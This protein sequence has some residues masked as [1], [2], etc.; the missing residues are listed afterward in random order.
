MPVI[1]HVLY[2]KICQFFIYNDQNLQ[3]KK[4]YARIITDVRLCLHV[5]LV[6]TRAPVSSSDI[7]QA[8]PPTSSQE[9]GRA[10]KALGVRGSTE[11]RCVPALVAERENTKT[12]PHQ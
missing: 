5:L 10:R 4:T 7:N 3:R 6:T 1:H 8:H 9:A 2:L 11:S 12:L